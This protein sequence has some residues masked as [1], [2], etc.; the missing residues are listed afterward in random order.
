MDHIV[1]MLDMH[2]WLLSVGM[3]L[4]SKAWKMQGALDVEALVFI[5][6]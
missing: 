3:I 5:E 6:V 1:G 4:I 2:W